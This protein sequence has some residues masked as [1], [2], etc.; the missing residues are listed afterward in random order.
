MLDYS[1]PDR[2][3]SYWVYYPSQGA[4][5]ASIHVKIFENGDFNGSAEIRDIIFEEEW[6]TGTVLIVVNRIDNVS[7]KKNTV[8]P[9]PVIIN[10]PFFRQPIE[11]K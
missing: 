6:R 3:K 10:D 2:S 9:Q 11:P 8:E 5:V 7:V 4:N 1:Y